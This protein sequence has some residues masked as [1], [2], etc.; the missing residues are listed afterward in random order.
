[1]STDSPKQAD[2]SLLDAE[3]WKVE[4]DAVIKDIKEFV[5]AITVSEKLQVMKKFYIKILS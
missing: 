2:E 4:A 1:M 5:N 3:G